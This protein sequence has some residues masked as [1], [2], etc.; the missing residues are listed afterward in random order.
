MLHA[1]YTAA[2]GMLPQL[3]RLELTAQNLANVS[4]AGYRR[5][6]LFQRALIQ[7]QQNLAHTPGDAET[8]DVPV[9][10]YTDFRPGA[11]Q[12]TGNPLDVALDGP[13][14]FVVQDALGELFLTRQGRFV[15]RADGT[16]TTLDGKLVLGQGGSPLQVPLVA[17]TT[18]PPGTSQAVASVLEITPE[19]QIRSGS[20]VVGTLWIAHAPVETLRRV[21]GVCFALAAGTTLTSLVPTQYR[22]VQGFLEGANV[23]PVEEL[24]QLIELQRQFEMGQRVIRA[25]DSTLDRS[26]EIARFV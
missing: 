14:F 13:G 23:N 26:I 9:V 2:L 21:D 12:K 25:N 11:L 24:V 6:A 7:A 16:L 19:G 1:L 3:T 17:G 15:L 20:A 8:A 18:Q 4:T 10:S 5:E 22:V